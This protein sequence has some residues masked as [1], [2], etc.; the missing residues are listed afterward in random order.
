MLDD[1]FDPFFYEEI[2]DPPT[3]NESLLQFNGIEDIRLYQYLKEIYFI[4][5]SMSHSNNGKNLIIR[6]KYDIVNFKLTNL[7]L[8]ESPY[9]L[10]CEKNW[11]PIIQNLQGI[12]SEFFIYKWFPME[13][14]RIVNSKLQ[15]ETIYDISSQI[16]SKF[17]GSS[18]FIQWG[19]FLLGVVHFSEDDFLERKYFHTLVMLDKIT[20]KPLKYSNPFYFGNE[21]S[22]EFCI[23]F[24][25]NE[26]KYHFWISI[27]DSDPMLL[28]IP[29]ECI[30]LINQVT[31]L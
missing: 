22:I 13:I 7:L 15:I 9:D 17:R 12:E 24:T 19:E 11:T 25:I 28:S 23:G 3:T 1:N 8:I 14:G 10:P 16:F 27:L 18:P 5:T 2:Y 29:L 21:P 20:M 6:G 26:L 31:Y 4:G 30:P